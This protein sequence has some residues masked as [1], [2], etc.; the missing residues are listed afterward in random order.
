MEGPHSLG[1]GMMECRIDEVLAVYSLWL[2]AWLYPDCL[3]RLACWYPFLYVYPNGNA[4][5]SKPELLGIIHV[6]GTESMLYQFMEI[7]GVLLEEVGA[8]HA[9]RAPPGVLG[10]CQHSINSHSPF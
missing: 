10:S 4:R 8:V 6:P 3:G 5:S 9:E 1:K 2:S 7:D